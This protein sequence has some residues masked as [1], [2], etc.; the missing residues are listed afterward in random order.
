MKHPC[1][2]KPKSP[3]A[4]EPVGKATIGEPPMKP[5]LGDFSDSKTVPKRFSQR[6][7][8]AGK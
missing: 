6:S 2:G 8:R 3:H 7:I 5:A 4:D 1:I